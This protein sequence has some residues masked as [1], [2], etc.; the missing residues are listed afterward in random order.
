MS[1]VF[2]ENK[3]LGADG[4]NHI[5]EGGYYP[6]CVIEEAVVMDT[7]EGAKYLEFKFKDSMG[8]ECNF[9][10]VYFLNKDRSE[11][12][13]LAKIHALMGLLGLRQTTKVPC[14][15]DAFGQPLQTV[16]IAEFVGKQIGIR[17]QREDYKKNDGSIGFEMKLLNFIGNDGKTYS[18]RANGKEGKTIDLSV[19]D[20]LIQEKAEDTSFSYGA[21]SQEELPAMN[22]Q[23]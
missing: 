17:I 9:V 1:F 6:N 16:R 10:R 8:R 23:W 7:K 2:D 12:F 15:V 13:A 21:N 3:A 18:E 11:N 14:T 19:K 4:G 20:K 5:V 22:E